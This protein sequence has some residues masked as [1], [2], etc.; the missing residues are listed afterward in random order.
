MTLGAHPLLESMARLGRISPYFQMPIKDPAEDGWIG[1]DE[2]FLTDDARLRHMVMSYGKSYWGSTNRHVAG[3]AFIIAYLTRLVWPVI[4]QYVLER[5][6][7]NVSL[8]NLAFHLTVGSS[9]IR[10]DATALSHPFFALLPNDPNVA[11]SDA[12]E[13]EDEAAL[14]M[15]LKQWLFD[16]NLAQV[17]ESLNRA[18]Q[19]SIKVSQNAVATACAQ[20]FHLLYPV[21]ENAD[22]IVQK[23]S[24]LFDDET[25]LVY[26]QVTMEVF[27]HQD[28]CG[29]F[30]RRRG[31]CLAWRTERFSG[32]CSNCILVPRKEQDR[33]FRRM[34]D[35]GWRILPSETTTVLHRAEHQA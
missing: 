30:A 13:V 14:Y 34:D 29:L 3:S 11:H 27:Q 20:A 15:R 32:Y 2:L 31:C 9:H 12:L 28:K 6:V 35:V 26:R 1:A 21:V 25:S 16:D 19:A 5:R 24:G 22:A 23:A 17:I 8:G 10:I 18:A 4:G 7:P 33:L